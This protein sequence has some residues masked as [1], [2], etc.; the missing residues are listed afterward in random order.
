MLELKRKHSRSHSASIVTRVAEARLFAPHTDLRPLI[1]DLGC[2]GT[3]ALQLAALG[4]S[5][6]G[7]DGAAY[8]LQAP[9][10]NALVVAGRV[11]PIWVPLL[12]AAYEGL[13]APKWVIAYGVCAISGVVF[14]TCPLSQAVPV[15]LFVMGCPPHMEALQDALLLLSRRRKP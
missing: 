14:N 1:L 9:E 5:I 2:C 8:N 6:S 7:L 12:R 15:D 3:S 13:G 11:S 4:S 10:A